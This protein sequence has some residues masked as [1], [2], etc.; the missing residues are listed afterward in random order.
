MNLE[1][2]AETLGGFHMSKQT[3]KDKIILAAIQKFSIHGYSGASTSQIAKEAGCAEG[4]IF[5]YF[6]KKIDL[7][8]HVA[9][10]FIKQ[11]AT[12]AATKS[13][14][15]IIKRADELTAEDLVAEILRDRIGL[16]RDNFEILK[17]VVYEINF[18]EE[19]RTVFIEEFQSNLRSVG[20]EIS[21][22]LAEKMGCESLDLSLILRTVLGQFASIF[23]QIHILEEVVA[24]NK[25]DQLDDLVEVS[26]KVIVSGLR[27]VAKC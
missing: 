21:E 20:Y 10:V 15:E 9:Q 2:M 27:G 17:I 8:K 7:L 14:K 13:L 6:P 5:R 3:T 4:T 25:H 1:V 26:A 23:I 11:F 16:I 12:G 18:H 19:V 24:E 22:L